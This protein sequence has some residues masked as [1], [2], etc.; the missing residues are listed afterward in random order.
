MSICHARRTGKP[1]A[2]TGIA[3]TCTRLHS[4]QLYSKNHCEEHVSEATFCSHATVIKS[5]DTQIM[6]DQGMSLAGRSFERI[7]VWDG[8]PLSPHYRQAPLLFVLRQG[9]ELKHRL[10]TDVVLDW[11]RVLARREHQHQRVEGHQQRLDTRLGR[12]IMTLS[13]CS[14]CLA[15]RA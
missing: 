5:L 7:I 15:L 6:F 10:V 9:L 2:R 12:C 11:L 13:S 4:A 14:S 8:H 3:V 1:H